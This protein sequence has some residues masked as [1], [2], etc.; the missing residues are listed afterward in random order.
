LAIPVAI[1]M[2]TGGVWGADAPVDDPRPVTIR[3][4][5]ESAMRDQPANLVLCRDR[6]GWE[7][8]WFKAP[9]FNASTHQ[10]IVT[11]GVVTPEKAD[12]EVVTSVQADS[13]I[14]GGYGRYRVSLARQSGNRFAGSYEGVFQDSNY[15]GRATAM[16]EFGA[17]TGEMTAKPV[18]PDEHPRLM[19]R[20]GDLPALKAKAKTPFGQAALAKLNGV[21]GL[22]LRYQLEGDPKYAEQAIP[23]V[24]ALMADSGLG[25][26]GVRGRVVGWRMEQVAL[27]YDL[28]FDAW[29]PEMRASVEGYLIREGW[30]PFTGTGTLHQEIAWD[31]RS[32]YPG[33]I[34]YGPAL[35]MLA[36]WGRKGDKP[37]PP[38]PPMTEVPVV[39][40]DADYS[41]GQGVTVCDLK[42]GA[43]P[44]EWLIACGFRDEG[45]ADALASIG[46]GAKARPEVGTKASDG[47]TNDTFRAIA[48]KEE[49]GHFGGF[50][51]MARATGRKWYTVA[52]LFTVI[53]NDEPGVVQI[54]TDS[55]YD[56][57]FLAGRELRHGALVR[58]EKGVYRFLIVT[59]VGKTNDWGRIEKK[60]RLLR[61]TE[62]ELKALLEKQA[63]DHAF[64]MDFYRQSLAAWE[65]SGGM[66][67]GMLS[68]F[69]A[70]QQSMAEYTVKSFGVNG[71]KTGDIGSLHG[72]NRYAVAYRNAFGVPLTPEADMEMFLPRQM[73]V[74]TPGG[75]SKPVFVDLLS[76]S[77]FVGHEYTGS[78][79]YT[80]NH[81][82][83]LFPLVPDKSQ[84]AVLWSWW[85]HLGIASE[86]E[87]VK[88]LEERFPGMPGYSR[89]A[90]VAWTF[91]H[92][93]LGMKPVPPTGVLPLTWKTD[94]LETYG[95]RNK[96]EGD[97]TC[98]LLV[99]AHCENRG[100]GAF[101]LAGF[102]RSWLAGK[103][104]RR[105]AENVVQLPGIELDDDAPALVTRYEA[106]NYGSGALTL[107]Y[108]Q[109]YRTAETGISGHR[110]FAVDYSGKSGA[111]VLVAIADRVVG[112]DQPVWTSPFIDGDFGFGGFQPGFEY[113]EKA[114]K[115]TDVSY[116]TVTKKFA[117]ELA[118]YVREKQGGSV[119]YK[120][121]AADREAL[122]KGMTI[123]G[124]T[125][126]IERDGVVLR[127]RVFSNKPVT[128]AKDDVEE[129]RLGAKMSVLH[130]VSSGLTARGGNE[131][132]VVI[133]LSKG[134]PP[135][136]EA[137][138]SGLA[139]K[140]K[141][142]ERSVSY[143]KDGVVIE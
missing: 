15:V 137:E 68:L 22:A 6:M 29:S 85:R 17:G 39:N 130:S 135:R 24:K 105:L 93:P 139:A 123:E 96:W 131:F 16:V 108:G 106:N 109:V 143:I 2:L 114:P 81:F 86:D 55:P 80:A 107:D 111:A 23:L 116:G 112:F 48:R 122:F 113:R 52:L 70:S 104:G 71:F 61:L 65:K 138:G 89:E 76:E 140:V 43:M 72:P 19:F 120:K 13:W 142:G 67:L 32:L 60:P 12:L 26:K 78:I 37:V 136:I 125:F 115:G 10:A 3:L 5:I 101:R 45:S 133:T 54:L 41:P 94:R 98:L 34:R 57:V 28:C 99:G 91:V 121:F 38:P 31:S 63:R 56:V 18:A 9:R 64:E 119:E 8:S 103:P 88:A 110:S 51:D 97:G 102:G 47:Q 126:R 1:A 46:G 4:T 27:T 124:D 20:K 33:A 84:P 132:L 53:R 75:G 79:D 127:G 95:F 44:A 62:A 92:Y 7:R 74:E 25:D 87:A 128:V 69:G 49:S 66:D 90:H 14:K 21:I 141:V 11:R 36:I 82:S 40:P 30:L 59:R 134:E 129:T 35:G 77:G 58:L 73:F 83:G 42:S 117:K 50:L 100:A 118:E